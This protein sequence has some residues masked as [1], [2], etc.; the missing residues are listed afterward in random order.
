MSPGEG[1]RGGPMLYILLASAALVTG[2]ILGFLGRRTRL[3]NRLVALQ[4]EIDGLEELI[5][6]ERMRVRPWPEPS[7]LSAPD[8]LAATSELPASRPARSRRPTSQ[9]VTGGA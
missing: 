1:V 4:R 9:T 5:A 8:W 2:W 6:L 3:Q 7:A